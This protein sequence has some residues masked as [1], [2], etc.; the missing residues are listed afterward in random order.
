MR[1]NHA[2]GVVEGNERWRKGGQEQK[3]IQRSNG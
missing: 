2:I 3:S 1:Q